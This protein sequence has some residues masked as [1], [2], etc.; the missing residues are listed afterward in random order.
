MK[1][2]KNTGTVGILILLSILAGLSG[3]A[4]ASEDSF[5]TPPNQFYGN[6]VIDGVG[7]P[8]GASISAYI[9]GELRGSLETVTA[10]EYGYDL[11]YLSV[12]GSESD[13]GM[14]ITFK[15]NGDVTNENDIYSAG[16]G[17]RRRD[18]SIGEPPADAQDTSQGGAAGS[19]AGISMPGALPTATPNGAAPTSEEGVT[20]ASTEPVESAT[21]STEAHAQAPTDESGKSKGPLPGFEAMFAITGLLAVAYLVR[22]RRR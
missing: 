10:G 9:D 14:T 7:A 5:P 4:A 11:N 16:T 22:R 8:A 15:V 12:T 1:E 13:D 18:L 2:N 6:V 20:P 3:I 19:G 21:T 17:P